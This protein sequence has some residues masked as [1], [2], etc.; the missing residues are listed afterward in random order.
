ML[1]DPAG[2]PLL[3]Y[4][5]AASPG[6][7]LSTP[8]AKTDVRVGGHGWSRALGGLRYQLGGAGAKSTGANLPC[9]AALPPAG[10]LGA[11]GAPSLAR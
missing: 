3:N 5:P 9:L 4:R 1:V 7:S 10:E 8:T 2:R 6:R 11:P